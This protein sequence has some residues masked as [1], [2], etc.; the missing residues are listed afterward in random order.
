M[1]IS[2]ALGNALSGLTVSSRSADVVS[3]NIANAMTEGYG[4]RS[5]DI[6]SRIGARDGS[7]AQVLGVLRDRDPVLTGQRRGADATLAWA[8]TEADHLRALETLIGLPDDAASLSARL[9]EFEARLID[10]ANGP[11]D[12]IRLGAAVEVADA[13]ARTFGTI[14]DGIQASRERADAAIGEAVTE[15]N[16]SLAGIA[17]LNAR[18]RAIPDRSGDLSSL[19]DAQTRLVDQLAR[20]I[21]LQTRRDAAGALQVF[22]T[23]GEILVD[24]KAVVLEFRTTPAI[25]TTMVF[26]NSILSGIRID[27]REIAFGTSTA[28]LGGAGL[29]ALFAQRDTWAP[30]AQARLDG[31]AR[32]LVERFETPGLDPTLLPTDA[33]LFTDAGARSDPGSEQGLSARITVNAAVRPE[34]GGAV[35]R[36]RDGLGA[37]VEGATGN[38]TNLLAQI[39]ALSVARVT[40]SGSFTATARTMSDLVSDHVSIVGLARQ[41]AE[42]RE[43]NSAA[44]QSALRQQ[45]LSRGVDTDAEMQNLIR[46]EQMYAANAR[47]VQAAEAMLDE[48]MR[49]TR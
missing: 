34:D 39:D 33:G 46:I 5:L 9:A 48:L 14:S 35:W 25:D 1:S 8:N 40:A 28:P 11:H 26:G 43:A 42:D 16:Q 30:E 41:G 38:P 19:L 2:S 45:E 36:L 6:G 37:T 24:R 17:E 27:G 12:E 22:S 13:L 32:D 3:S 7:G 15:I 20:H 47:V 29:A 4:V 49:M 18:I 21:P 10:A 31:V 44:V 23:G